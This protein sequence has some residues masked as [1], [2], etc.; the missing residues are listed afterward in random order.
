MLG[1]LNEQDGYNLHFEIEKNQIYDAAFFINTPKT[2]INLKVKKG[3]VI[4]L[5][6]EPAY[7]ANL[8]FGY[9][10]Y[11]YKKLNQ[12][13]RVFSVI[14]NAD[15]IIESQPYLGWFENNYSHKDWKKLNHINKSK[16]I[17]CISSDKLT[18]SGHKKRFKFIKELRSTDLPIDYFGRGYNELADKHQGLRDY[19]YSIAIENGSFKNYFTEKIMDCFLNWTIP[20]YYGCPN[21]ENFF[22][23]DSFILIDI[24]DFKKSKNIIENI[25]KNDNYEKRLKAL[26]M[27]RNLVLEKYN[28]YSLI[29]DN[30][31]YIKNNLTNDYK[32][33]KIKPVISLTGKIKNKLFSNSKFKKIR[34]FIYK[35]IY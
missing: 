14:K 16:T 5:M 8:L 23:K 31:L 10:L 35:K 20:I 3:N 13:D 7:K 9:N 26:E 28:L 33:Y 19:K 4:C 27:A 6:G 30:E 34:D 29:K 25:I 2:T 1:H 22:P 12:Y 18:T 11:M 21:I 32:D 15:N 24:E 17:S